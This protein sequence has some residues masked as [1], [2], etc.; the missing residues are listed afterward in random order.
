ML[1]SVMLGLTN[2]AIIYPS[3]LLKKF[4]LFNDSIK[5]KYHVFK[6]NLYYQ[7]K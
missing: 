6:K 7:R 4:Q 1:A 3:Y 5:R 2:F